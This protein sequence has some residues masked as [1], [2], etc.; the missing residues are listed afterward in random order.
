METI[1]FFLLKSLQNEFNLITER[2]KFLSKQYRQVYNMV[3]YTFDYGL[4]AEPYN[5]RK[6]AGEKE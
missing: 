2:I 1:N 5:L 4:S 6:M 3:N